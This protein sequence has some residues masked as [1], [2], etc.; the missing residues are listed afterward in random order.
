VGR[1]FIPGLTE[2]ANDNGHLQGDV[3]DDIIDAAAALAGS[4]DS[5]FG[6]YSPRNLTW[7][8]CTSSS[9]NTEF[10]FLTSRRS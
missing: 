6:V 10:A 4:L 5:S 7:R 3:R 9:V 2:T 1:T 8:A